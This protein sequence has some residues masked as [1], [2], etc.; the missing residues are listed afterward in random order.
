LLQKVLSLIGWKKGF[1]N[2]NLNI[3][4]DSEKEHSGANWSLHLPQS[5]ISCLSTMEGQKSYYIKKQWT[6][7]FLTKQIKV[8]E[9]VSNTKVKPIYH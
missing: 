5:H 3:S 7:S 1:D 4:N 9:V 6:H 2:P 8:G